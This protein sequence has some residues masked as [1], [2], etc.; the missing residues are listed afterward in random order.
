MA[1]TLSTSTKFVR[2]TSGV[3]AA[4]VTRL[5]MARRKNPG[6]L[7]AGCRNNPAVGRRITSPAA[8]LVPT[9]RVG[10]PVSPLCGVPNSGVRKRWSAERTTVSSHAERG[11]EGGRAWE[12]GWVTSSSLFR[13][14]AW[15]HPFSPLCGVPNSGV[16][17]RWSAERTTVRSHAE[18]GNEGETTRRWAAGSLP[19]RPECLQVFEVHVGAPLGD[20]LQGVTRVGQP[21]GNANPE[22]R[23]RIGAEIDL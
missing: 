23:F 6:I 22:S 20:Q 14:S 5:V 15:E 11:N 1:D 7:T 2:Q 18:R 12:R 13:R 17:K 3:S 9:L 8:V 16:R 21:L 19:R 4:S 10:T